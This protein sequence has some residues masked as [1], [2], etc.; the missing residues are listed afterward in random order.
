MNIDDKIKKIQSIT[1]IKQQ[2]WEFKKYYK[3]N[4]FISWTIGIALGV[5]SGYLLF[6]VKSKK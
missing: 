1:D 2:A 3:I 5:L 4:M 6:G